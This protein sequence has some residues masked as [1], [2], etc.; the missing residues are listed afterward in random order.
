MILYTNTS[1]K[2]I[3]LQNVSTKLLLKLQFYF[4]SF[5]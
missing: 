4:L 3:N 1:I 2:Y 5:R